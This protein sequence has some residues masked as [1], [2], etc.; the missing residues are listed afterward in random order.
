MDP[1][2]ESCWALR[3]IGVS[4][5]K[6]PLPTAKAKELAY[7]WLL[8]RRNVKNGRIP[9]H[10]FIVVVLSLDPCFRVAYFGF[11]SFTWNLGYFY[12]SRCLVARLLTSTES[13][14]RASFQI[15]S[16]YTVSKRKLKN[17]L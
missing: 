15:C 17:T 1:R 3:I 9:A 14:E 6:T 10:R 2:H 7:L 16:Q 13:F 12:V 4:V 11:V 8:G 5:L